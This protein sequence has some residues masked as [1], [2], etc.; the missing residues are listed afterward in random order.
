[1]II[2]YKLPTLYDQ[3]MEV[4]YILT[5]LEINNGNSSELPTFRKLHTINLSYCTAAF[6]I[7]T[8]IILSRVIWN[9]SNI[10]FLSDLLVR[11]TVKEEE[12]RKR[13]IYNLS[14]NTKSYK[15]KDIN[16]DM[17]TATQVSSSPCC[18]TCK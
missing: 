3:D 14:K 12:K 6:K 10:D 2:I 15:K 8:N 11:L 16:R 18:K 9:T 1:M 5:Y 17:V 13:R 4:I 7:A